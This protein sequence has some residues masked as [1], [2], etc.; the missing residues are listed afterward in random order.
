MTPTKLV[1]LLVFVL[2]GS[3]LP[4][5]VWGQVS[6]TQPVNLVVQ[7]DGQLK[8]K[9]P[10]RAIYT[11][12]VFGTKLYN[13]DLLDLEKSSTAGVVCSDL[14]LR[15]VP[16]GIAAVPCPVS[17][18]VLK[19]KD[20]TQIMATRGAGEGSLP[21]VLSPRKTRLITAHPTLRWTPVK[22]AAAYKVVV[23]GKNVEWSTV[24][25]SATELVYPQEAP[26]LE[27]DTDYRV[28]VTADGRPADE[29][30]LGPS[31]SLLKSDEKKVVL[32]ERRQ[33]ESLGLPKGPTQFLIAHL[34][35]DHALYAEAIEQLDGVSK[36]FKVAAVRRLLGDL[37][38]DIGLPQQA[39]ADYVNAL[40]LA[41]AEND[42]ESQ[43]LLH[44]A[45]AT[46]YAYSLNERTLARQHLNAMLD[47]AKKLGDSKTAN[48]AGK[49]LAELTTVSPTE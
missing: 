33:V 26:Q 1:P 2:H 29:H 49:Q 15:Q 14:T 30:G 17:R 27:G 28:I 35:A 11:P 31:F 12:V 42:D 4:P 24:V 48:L 47:L 6:R 39:E 8:V 7:I 16:S 9:R 36:T 46:I 18:V 23:Q 19:Q 10:G 43:M 3:F 20:G 37:Q 40:E 22:G 34:Y 38:M 45:L 41:T 5:T 13:G 44:Q 21:L 25:T 32:Q